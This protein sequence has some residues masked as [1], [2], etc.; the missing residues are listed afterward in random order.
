M[1]HLHEVTQLERVKPKFESLGPVDFGAYSFYPMSHIL[2]YP[3]LCFLICSVRVRTVPTGWGPCEDQ[4]W[5]I[6]IALLSVWI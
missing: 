2:A 4:R 6:L 1:S 3:G 5:C